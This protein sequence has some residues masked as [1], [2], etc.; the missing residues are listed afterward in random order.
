[1]YKD[2][3]VPKVEIAGLDC[4]EFALTFLAKWDFAIIDFCQRFLLV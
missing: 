2:P 4:A 1:M 3:Y